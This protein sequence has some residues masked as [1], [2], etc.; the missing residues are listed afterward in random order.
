MI[1]DANPF[2]IKYFHDASVDFNEAELYAIRKK[3]IIDC[4]SISK[5]NIKKS[6]A[7]ISRKLVTKNE[8]HNKMN[9]IWTNA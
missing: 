1:L 9:S 7:E 4:S 8:M 5:K 3:N 2:T 6:F